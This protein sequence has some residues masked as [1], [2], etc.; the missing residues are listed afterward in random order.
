MHQLKTEEPYNSDIV[1]QTQLIAGMA[2]NFSI[3]YY[4]SL[5]KNLN[6]RSKPAGI[7]Q[8]LNIILPQRL[9]AVELKKAM[10]VSFV[11]GGGWCALPCF[12]K[13]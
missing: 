8:N 12:K 11:E 7:R 1:I 6:T 10:L 3:R 9:N 2:P 4:Q 5:V 13:R